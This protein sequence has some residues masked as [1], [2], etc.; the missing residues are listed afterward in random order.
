M[1]RFILESLG[2]IHND[3]LPISA[4]NLPVFHADVIDDVR[5]MAGQDKLHTTTVNLQIL[6]DEVDAVYAK[7]VFKLV[8]QYYGTVRPK[9]HST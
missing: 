5:M 2:A 7:T 4:Y 3:D 8:D 1:A 6:R 9:S